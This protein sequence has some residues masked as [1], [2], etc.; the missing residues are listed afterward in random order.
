MKGRR[1]LP[2]GFPA[3]TTRLND[4]TGQTY[5][6]ILVGLTDRQISSLPPGIIGIA[7]TSSAAELAEIYSVADWFFNPTHE[8]NYPTVNLEA[9]ACGCRVVTYDTGGSAETV[10][11][12]DKAWVLKGAE[13]SPEGFVKLLQS[14]EGK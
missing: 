9:R 10:E 5:F 8:D 12:Y 3:T 14:L 11:G 7:R 4:K 1:G 13:K 2:T 6:I